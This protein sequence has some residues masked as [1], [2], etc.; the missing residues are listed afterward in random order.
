MQNTPA[1]DDGAKCAW[2]LAPVSCLMLGE[3]RRVSATLRTQS[4]RVILD[5]LDLVLLLDD[6]GSRRRWLAPGTRGAEH[7]ETSGASR[8]SSLDLDRSST[9]TARTVMNGEVNVAQQPVANNTKCALK[10]DIAR[11][12]MS[13]SR[14]KGHWSSGMRRCALLRD[15][16]TV[17]REMIAFFFFFAFGRFLTYRRLASVTLGSPD[18]SRLNSQ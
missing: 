18:K 8:Q 13:L 6:V 5:A 4:E 10:N 17:V 14:L 1:C 15:V 12:A 3:Q 2:K 9:S 7:S 16:A 11:R